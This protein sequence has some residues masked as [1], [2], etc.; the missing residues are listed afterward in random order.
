LGEVSPNCGLSRSHKS[1]EDNVLLHYS[2]EN[3]TF[4]DS[5]HEAVSAK[6]LAWTQKEL[7]RILKIGGRPWRKPLLFWRMAG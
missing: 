6:Y 7:L 1:D 2:W 5:I 3:S 4:L